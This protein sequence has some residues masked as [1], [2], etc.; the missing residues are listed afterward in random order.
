MVVVVGVHAVFAWHD[1]RSG[2]WLVGVAH[3]VGMWQA[4]ANPDEIDIDVDD[5]DDDEDGDVEGDMDVEKKNVPAAVFGALADQA[6]TMQEEQAVEHMGA[7]E[8]MR[9]KKREND[10]AF[11]KMKDSALKEAKAKKHTGWRDQV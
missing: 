11:N 1:V 10:A 7:L 3:G 8:R 6:A 5:D 4:Q 9:Q 2:G